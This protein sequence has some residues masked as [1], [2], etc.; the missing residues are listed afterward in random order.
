M[1]RL[2]LGGLVLIG[3]SAVAGAG[4]LPAAAG[5]ISS[6]TQEDARR[7]LLERDRRH[8]PKSEE[9]LGEIIVVSKAGRERRKVW[10]SYRSGPP[11]DSDRLIQFLSP[12]DVRGVG[13]LAHFRRGKSPDEWLY[14]PSMK[15]ERRIGTRDREGAFAATSFSYEDLDLL[16]FDETRYDAVLLPPQE[17]GGMRTHV[18][19]LTP[20]VPSAYSRKV[21][22]LRQGDLGLLTVEYYVA[23][24][25]APVKRMTLAN[26]TT[27]D[28]YQIAT[29]VEMADLRKGDHTTVLLHDVTLDR[30]QPRDRYTIQNLRR[31]DEGQSRP[32]AGPS[33][34]RQGPPTGAGGPL[35]PPAAPQLPWGFSGYVEGR[36]FLGLG[37][38]AANQSALWAT[39]FLRQTARVGR[40]RVTGAVRLESS[41]SSQVGPVV[42]DPADRHSRRS[43]ISVRE[44]SL[45][46]PLGHGLDLQVGRFQPSWGGADG[47]SPSDAFLPRDLSD[48]LTEE[49]LPIWGA[50]LRGEVGP[51]RF[52]VL[53][54]PTTT[55]WR[56]PALG[57]SQSAFAL[58]NV[59][60]VERPWTV[61]PVGFQAARIESSVRGWDLEGWAR[62]GWLP[63]PVLVPEL[64]A[65]ESALA[66]IGSRP[67]PVVDANLAVAPSTFP[68]AALLAARAFTA[69]LDAVEFSGEEIAVP[70]ERHFAAEHGAGVSL[71]RE[72][73]GWT[74]HSEIGVFRSRDLA[75][76]NSATWT[77]GGSR[78]VRNGTIAATVATNVIAPPLDP[79]LLF[80]RALLPCAIL[81]VREYESWGSWGAVWLE[82]FRTVGGVLTAEI[83]RD[84]TDVVKVTA[85]ADLPHGAP[86]S[87]ANAFSGGQRVRVALRWSW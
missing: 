15:R 31:E 56:L 79:L 46:V 83:T 25:P 41:S 65:V 66:R 84:M 69:K 6:G 85:G 23:R 20:R 16:E 72:Y 29:R 62:V 11:G 77:I 60:L 27:V 48:P 74:I 19:E 70:L 71:A 33:A 12:P 53:A 4:V 49:R 57:G 58:M 18:I 32:G 37:D 87:P 64:D 39:V 14:L 47:Y 80:D 40:A 3:L 24:D 73:G 36:S 78:I 35:Q 30:P 61:P 10:R 45:V 63:A 21:L 22:T 55:P 13:Y 50:S 82:T 38:R 43:P 76:G 2:G 67:A 59:R 28:G 34:L 26:Y 75:L 8:R 9:Y 51:V 44:L 68:L 81:A 1:N 7:I 52:E 5:P 54:T 86:L 17:V 42:F